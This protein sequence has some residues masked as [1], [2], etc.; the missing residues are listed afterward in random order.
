MNNKTVTIMLWV[1]FGIMWVLWIL[2]MAGV[3]VPWEKFDI[4]KDFH[5][6]E[7]EVQQS[8]QINV[9]N[10]VKEE[11]EECPNNICAMENVATEEKCDE[12]WGIR[13]PQYNKCVDVVK[14]EEKDQE[15]A[16]EEKCH[17]QWWELKENEQGEK[18][19]IPVYKD[20][21]KTCESS[22]DCESGLCQISDDKDKTGSCNVANPFKGCGKFLNYKKEVMDLCA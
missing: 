5:E 6:K 2:R 3:L 8:T 12:E 7:K 13:N 19:C 21:G 1:L 11:K 14:Q 20:A 10:E 17:A 16:I 22:L 18:E 9:N 4:T 15:L